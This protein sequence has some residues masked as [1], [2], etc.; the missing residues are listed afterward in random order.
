MS[1]VILIGMALT[2]FL[3]SLLSGV[4]GMAGGLILLWVLLLMMPVGTAIAVHGVI[5]MVANGSRAWFSRHYID[6]RILGILCFGLAVSAVV[7]LAVDY[8]PNII[9]VSIAIGLMPILVWLPV[10]R[11]QLDASRPSH[12]L[13]CGVIS[14]ALMV[15]VGVSGPVIDIFFIRTAMDRRKVIATKAATQLLAHA[16][17]V[18]FYWRAATVLPGSD[19]IAILFAAPIAILGTRAG[20]IILQRMTDANFRTWTR[21]IV[22]GVGGV[23]IVQG[24]QQL[25]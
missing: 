2:V 8:A 22:T 3:T 17:K 1:P 16:T 4:F 20:N 7:L 15:G 24:L 9:V 12:S 10:Q 6:Y 25:M 21:W 23:Y 5:Q 11:L 13:V 19:W 18:I 14:G